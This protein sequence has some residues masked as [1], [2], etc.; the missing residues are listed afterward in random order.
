MINLNNYTTRLFLALLMLFLSIH[1]YAQDKKVDRQ[2]M[3]NVLFDS[4]IDQSNARAL[5]EVLLTDLT[6]K[7]NASV[8]DYNGSQGTDF[9]TLYQTARDLGCDIF[10]H[11][12][13]KARSGFIEGSYYIYDIVIETEVKNE[14]LGNGDYIFEDL[15]QECRRYIKP[16]P[17]KTLEQLYIDDTVVYK[18]VIL[19]L[20]A[21]PGTRVSGLPESVIT[22][23]ESGIF[24]IE[25]MQNSMYELMV[26]EPGKTPFTTD[27]HIGFEDLYLKLENTVKEEFLQL[28]LG[29]NYRSLTGITALYALDPGHLYVGLGLYQSFLLPAPPFY[30]EENWERFD[31]RTIDFRLSMMYSFM[32]TN[33]GFRFSLAGDI[34]TTFW[35]PLSYSDSNLDDGGG[36][37]FHPT[38]QFFAT[39]APR[40]ELKI[41][42]KTYFT[43]EITP[44]IF[45]SDKMNIY[46]ESFHK[47]GNY[48]RK[49]FDD[50][51]FYIQ[52][53]N[54][55]GMTFAFRD[56][57]FGISIYL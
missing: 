39:I 23:P 8:F 56:I 19:T 25:L 49:A 51:S 29:T 32:N 54:T 46:Y 1:I 20:Q 13:L 30:A 9:N 36:L 33:A 55:S 10:V 40:V 35:N 24:Q 11:I 3:V 28:H 5:Q 31:L 7:I 14:K 43:V 50:L 16:M 15:V 47:E 41:A 27:F 45:Y 44:T 21:L 37:L 12:Q 34:G 2:L 42:D 48:N 26:Q 38:Y 57:F 4:S 53:D 22:I 17:R 18:G 52:V 6:R